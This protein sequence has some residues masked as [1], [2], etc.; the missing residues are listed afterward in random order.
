[1]NYKLRLQLMD[2]ITLIFIGMIDYIRLNLL[3]TVFKLYCIR[4]KID[5]FGLGSKEGAV[6]ISLDNLTLLLQTATKKR[7][8]NPLDLVGSTCSTGSDKQQQEYVYKY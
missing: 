1:M 6:R 3:A 2:P 7:T 8:T 5:F 4:K